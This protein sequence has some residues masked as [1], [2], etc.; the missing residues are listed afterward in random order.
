M[1][2]TTSKINVTHVD[3][4]HDILALIIGQEV[5]KA[6]ESVDRKDFLKAKVILTFDGTV[7]AKLVE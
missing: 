7:Q 5:V 6:L 3:C 4:D 2:D 1:Q